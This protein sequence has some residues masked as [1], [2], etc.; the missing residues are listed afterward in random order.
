MRYNHS[1]LRYALILILGLTT[2]SIPSWA[3]ERDKII[4]A[5]AR[6][7][8]SVGALYAQEENGD[9]KFLCSATAVGRHEKST[10]ILS[11]NHC[12]RKG[13][14]YLVNFGDNKLRSVR[15]WKIPHYEV[16]KEKF[17]RRYNEPE[18]DMALFLMA[19]SDIPIVPLA[20]GEAQVT[21]AR[22][23]MVGFPLGV[24]KIAYEGIIAGKFDRLGADFYGYLLLQIFGAPG[25]SGSAVVSVDTGNVVGILVAAKVNPGLPVIFATPIQY[26]DHLIQV[27]PDKVK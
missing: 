14:S 6:L 8:P 7:Q 2:F 25:S 12:L 5:L 19:G 20:N 13:V 24:A 16:D 9:M 26:Q 21:G 23:V 4:E 15:V 10:I 18:T 17:P 1:Q 11:A 27:A 22:V 3:G